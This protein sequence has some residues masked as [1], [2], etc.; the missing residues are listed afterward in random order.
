MVSG[1][2]NT[3][4]FS[5]SNSCFSSF[6]RRFSW[7]CSLKKSS[8]GWRK[9]VRFRPTAA[10]SDWCWNH[11]CRTNSLTIC[12]FVILR[13]DRRTLCG[14]T[15]GR[16]ELPCG[17]I[18][19]TSGT[20]FGRLVILTDCD[21]WL[22]R[23]RVYVSLS[24]TYDQTRHWRRIES[25]RCNSIYLRI[26]QLSVNFIIRK[27]SHRIRCW[28]LSHCLSPWL[29]VFF[30]RFSLYFYTKKRDIF[31]RKGFHFHRLS[32]SNVLDCSLHSWVIYHF[33]LVCSC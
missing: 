19:L 3:S 9:N 27:N 23:I 15:N 12:V 4:R 28:R 8:R 1:R 26:E 24:C 33:W 32:P 14:R 31:H 16:V 11:C 7:S 30:F 17:R 21:N 29:S 6:S 25:Q 22:F 13:R 5:S 2:L 18:F 20:P 10:W